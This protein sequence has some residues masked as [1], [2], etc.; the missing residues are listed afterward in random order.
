MSIHEV[1][2]ALRCSHSMKTSEAGLGFTPAAES[3]LPRSEFDYVTQLLLTAPAV[4]SQICRSSDVC[5]FEER[6]G[7]EGRSYY[8]L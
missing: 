2:G 5:T 6:P 4:K 7:L 1:L 3:V 8:R